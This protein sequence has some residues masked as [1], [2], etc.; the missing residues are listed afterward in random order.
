MRMETADRAGAI[1]RVAAVLIA[2]LAAPLATLMIGVG[3]F[4]VLSSSHW[5]FQGN[6]RFAVMLFINIVEYVVSGLF[7]PACKILPVAVVLGAMVSAAFFLT[8]P[9]REP[10]MAFRS[11]G[12]RTDYIDV[13]IIDDKGPVTRH[14]TRRSVVKVVR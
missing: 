10:D 4:I 13:E 7:C 9:K 1:A 12:G 6:R 11:N 2:L 14:R 3:D 5:R 8:G